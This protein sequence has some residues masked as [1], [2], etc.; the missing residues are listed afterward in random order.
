EHLIWGFIKSEDDIKTN[1]IALDDLADIRDTLRIEKMVF[2]GKGSVFIET[3]RKRINQILLANGALFQNGE[4]RGH[5]QDD[6][7]ISFNII[8]PYSTG[9]L[10]GLYPSIRINP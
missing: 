7:N 5:A 1:T 3:F 6:Q 10:K 9:E 8:Q 2:S 4:K